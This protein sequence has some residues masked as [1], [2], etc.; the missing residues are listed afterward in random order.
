MRILYLGNNRLGLKIISWL[1]E[2]NEK[3]VGVVVH[4][5]QKAKF[6]DEIVAKASTDVIIDGLTLRDPTVVE[7]VRNLNADIALSILF[8]YILRPSFYSVFPQGVV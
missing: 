4:P 8:G 5:A 1:K 6:R 3:S 2:Q 7:K